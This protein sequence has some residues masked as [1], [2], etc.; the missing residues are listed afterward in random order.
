MYAPPVGS[1]PRGGPADPSGIDAAWEEYGRRI[2]MLSRVD[3]FAT[4]SHEVLAE[5]ARALRPVA[6]PAGDVIVREG[7]VGEEFFLIEAG[8]LA[9][10]IGGEPREVARLGPGEFF[11]EAALLG[12]GLRTATVRAVTDVDLWALSAPK[13]RELLRLRPE[14]EQ[15][16]RRT[17]DQ[18]G[19]TDRVFEVEEHDLDALTQGRPGITIGRAP[20]NAI[21][22][23]SPLVSGEHAVIEPLAGGTFRLRDLGSLNG[24][25]VNRVRVRT[26]ELH[27]G[28]EIWIADQHFVFDHRA[29]RRLIEPE[30]IRLDA[31]GLEH[32]AQGR[33]APPRQRRPLDPAGRVRCDRRRQRRRQDD[34]AAG[35]V[36]GPAAHHRPGPLRRSATTT[37]TST[38][39]AASSDT[40]PRTT[41]STPRCPSA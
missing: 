5:L 15:L 2:R 23:D 22:F 31:I 9:I 18:R 10:T 39:S 13:L 21:V 6:A 4:A 36:G 32:R 28:D 37:A 38:G 3:L 19:R 27:D 11:G 34:A 7:D 30:G 41:S 8:T 17:A 20:E 14:I 24:T 35:A 33:Q 25:F 29:I 1:A 16:L 12:E 40:C 26:A